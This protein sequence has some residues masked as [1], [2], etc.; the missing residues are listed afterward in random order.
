MRIASVVSLF[1]DLSE[2][3][4]LWELCRKDPN[5]NLY[6]TTKPLFT[7]CIQGDKLFIVHF[8]DLREN[9]IKV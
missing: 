3:E 6:F 9:T 8:L 1:I 4:S 7:G 2:G 5:T